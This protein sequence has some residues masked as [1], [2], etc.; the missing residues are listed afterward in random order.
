MDKIVDSA[1]ASG[2]IC[3]QKVRSAIAAGIRLEMRDPDIFMFRNLGRMTVKELDCFDPTDPLTWND[4]ELDW[5]CK[6]CGDIFITCA[7]LHVM[8]LS[9]MVQEGKSPRLEHER[10]LASNGMWLEGPSEMLPVPGS[11]RANSLKETFD[12]LWMQLSHHL[13]VWSE[14]NRVT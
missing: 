5:R 14:K 10:H 13:K 12:Q 3:Y 1:T 4:E 2:P 8:M 11:T 9:K 6:K 7:V